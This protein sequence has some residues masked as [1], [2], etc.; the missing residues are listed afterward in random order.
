MDIIRVS[1]LLTC[2]SNTLAW[3]LL[4][5]TPPPPPPR[6]Q[7]AGL[8]GSVIPRPYKQ[9]GQNG[10]LAANA[11]PTS[12]SL[13]LSARQ[14]GKTVRQLCSQCQVHLLP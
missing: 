6:P 12:S 9:D 7:G 1:A 8:W 14:C 13:S 5:I 2:V 3:V 11:S 10:S 4:D